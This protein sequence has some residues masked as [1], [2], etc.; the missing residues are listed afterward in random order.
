[1]WLATQTRPD[2]ANVVRAVASYCA[3]PKQGHWKTVLGILRYL[4]RT[5]WMGF[6]FQRDVVDGLSMQVLVDA[7]Y[8]SKA[9]DRRSVSESLVLCG[10]GCVSWFSR[11]QKRVTLLTTEAE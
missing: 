4:R 1:M 8:A 10:G 3:S 2:I 7:D 11:M 6:T 5:K 9:T